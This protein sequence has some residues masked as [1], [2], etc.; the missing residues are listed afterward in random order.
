MHRIA[1]TIL[2]TAAAS[3]T[4]GCKPEAQAASAIGGPLDPRYRADWTQTQ[5]TIKQEPVC[6]A[7]GPAPLVHIFDVAG[8][9]RVI[10]MTAQNQLASASVPG[11]TLVSIDQRKGVT[12]GSDNVQPGPL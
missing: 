4:M 2:V 12:I 5:L 9:I 3:I 8:P 7:Q 10:D 1:I 6:V 11:R